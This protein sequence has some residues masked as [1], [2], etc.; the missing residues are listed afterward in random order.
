MPSRRLPL[1]DAIA[2]HECLKR[3]NIIG[4]LV[5]DIP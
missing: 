2:A 4:N 1:A 5:L 3:G